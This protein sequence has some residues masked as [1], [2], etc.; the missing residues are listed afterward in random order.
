MT[1]AGEIHRMTD[2]NEIIRNAI[3]KHDKS[4][5]QKY[6]EGMLLNFW[7]TEAFKIVDSGEYRKFPSVHAIQTEA[8]VRAHKRLEEYKKK[9]E[10]P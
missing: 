3:K 5:E 4:L 1:N 6:W 2:V 8:L 7:A 9:K 10:E